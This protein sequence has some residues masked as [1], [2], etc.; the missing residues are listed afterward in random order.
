MDF[1]AAIFHPTKIRFLLSAFLVF[2]WTA[3]VCAQGN[4]HLGRVPVNIGLK[5]N[6]EYNDNIFLDPRNEEDD[7]IHTITPSIELMYPGTNPGNFVKASYSVGIARYDDFSDTD[8]EEHQAF[9]GFSYHAPAGIYIKADDFYQNTADPY[10]SDATYNQGVQTER[11]NNKVKLTVGYEFA[12]VYTVEAYARNFVER[13]DLERDQFQDRTR[14]TFGGI[15]FYRFNRLQLLGEF[16]WVDV[17]FDEQK[18]GFDGW[19]KNNRQDHDMTEVLFGF[20]VQPGRKLDGDFKVGYQSVSFENDFDKNGNE[21]DDDSSFIYEA[22]LKYFISE[23]TIVHLSGGRTRNASVT[24]GRAYDVAASFFNTYW[25]IGLT[26]PMMTKFTWNAAYNGWI[27]DYL[28]ESP[29]FPD[30]ELVTHGFEGGLKYDLNK[31]LDVGLTFT[32]RNKDASKNLYKEDEY[33]V[34]RLGFYIEGK[35]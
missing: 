7:Y 26:L 27:E 29:G 15:L 24:A 5:Y 23:R 34:K 3:S 11:W 28:D 18:G 16:R 19:T 17:T 10:G 22:D 35:Y 4:L 13:Y 8:Y 30:K 12:D 32:Y 20:R 9:A 25:G 31:W 2:M 21:Y 1:K 33:T 6:G 14:N